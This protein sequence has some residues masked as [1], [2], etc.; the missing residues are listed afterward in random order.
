MRAAILSPNGLKNQ[1]ICLDSGRQRQAKQPGSYA[2]KTKKTNLAIAQAK[3]LLKHA[4]P[5]R[6]R[7]QWQ[8]PLDHH[9]QRQRLPK[10]AGVQGRVIFWQVRLQARKHWL[11]CRNRAWP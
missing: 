9:Q 1:L 10:H 7:H 11:H 8:E 3:K 2:T 5:D 6:R 4:A